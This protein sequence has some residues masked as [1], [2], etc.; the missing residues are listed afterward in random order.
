MPSVTRDDTAS[1]DV[2]LTRVQSF[3]TAGSRVPRSLF[4]EHVVF[5]QMDPG[6]GSVAE[7]DP[8]EF[9]IIARAV[10]S[11]QREFAA[12]RACAHRALRQLG[13]VAQPLLVASDRSPAWP[14]GIVGSISHTE[15]ICG[16]AVARRDV[17]AGIGF[18]VELAIPLP[19][20]VWPAVLTGA[21]RSALMTMDDSE[22]GLRARLVFSAKEAFYKCHRS[23]G[24]GW[25]DFHD[26]ELRM[27]ADADDIEVTCDKATAMHAEGRYAIHDGVIAVG[28]TVPR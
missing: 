12:G 23:A 10:E 19:L 3:L 13:G 6:F 4:P 27:T 28:F 21:E 17:I 11:R 15:G 5:E 2:I 14:E 18:D 1:H 26:V 24:G 16:A 25:L 8:A 9:D 22:R 7:L 20:D